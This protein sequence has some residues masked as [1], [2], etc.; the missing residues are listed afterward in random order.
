MAGSASQRPP[1]SARDFPGQGPNGPEQ[2]PGPALA[3][4]KLEEAAGTGG[5]P[6][7]ETVLRDGGPFETK[8]IAFAIAVSRGETEMAR[9]LGTEGDDM[10]KPTGSDYADFVVCGGSIAMSGY[11]GHPHFPQDFFQIEVDGSNL[12][13]I[14]ALA[15]EGFFGDGMLTSMVSSCLYQVGRYGQELRKNEDYYLGH[16]TSRYSE[17]DLASWR[18]K[19][20]L[21]LGAAEELCGIAGDRLDVPRLLEGRLDVYAYE[22]VTRFLCEHFPDSI[23]AAWIPTRWRF[24]EHELERREVRNLQIVFPYIDPAEVTRP[25][26]FMRCLAINGMTA[27][28]RQMESWPGMFSEDNLETCIEL[29]SRNGHP[30]TA[31]FL[32]DRKAQL[33]PSGGDDGNDGLLLL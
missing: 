16:G 23:S 24:G 6:D 13:S 11:Q 4:R 27:E 22:K 25:E 33:F 7:V 14:V 2:V 5:I 9:L 3:S 30:D 18:G 32:L 10:L 17:E 28:L 26:S 29:A 15:R 8:T 31:A 19:E 20:A 21:Y 1:I 12:S